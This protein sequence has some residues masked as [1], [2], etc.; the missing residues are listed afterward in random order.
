MN[1]AE[2]ATE[3]CRRLE[4]RLRVLSDA[5]R[6][7]AGATADPQ[8]LA[9]TVARRVAEAVKDCREL[10]QSLADHAALA[11]TNAHLLADAGRER[12]ERT[13]IADRLR[14]LSEAAKDFSA[15][16]G[17]LDQ[18]LE[19]IARRLGELVGDLCAIRPVSDDGEWLEAGAAYHR[20][21]ELLAATREIML[22]KPQRVGEGISGRVAAT[23]QALLTP[24]TETSAFIASSEPRYRPYLE[25]LG[26]ASSMAIPLLCRGK[27][28]GVASLLRSSPGHPYTED[29]LRFVQSVADHAALA[30]GNAQ[31]HAAERAARDAA[32]K[33]TNALRRSE[34]RFARLSEAGILG[35]LVSDLEGHVSEVNET[36]LQLVGYSR[37]EILSGRV[38]WKSLTPSE[39]RDVDARAVAQLT[40]SGVAGLREK[41]VIHKDGRRVPILAGSAMLGNESNTCISFL[42][43]LTE[44]KEAQAAI[45]HLHEER[46]V[47]ARFRGLLE[48]AP[49]AMVIV[50]SDGSIA[51]VNAQAEAL[52]GYPRA[53]MVGRPVELLIPERFR[54]AHP[55]R[56]AGYFRNAAARPMDG[57][58]ELYGRRKDGSEFPIEVSLSPLKTE[59]GNLVS[60]AIRDVTERKKAE[61]QRASLTATLARAKEGAESASRELEAFSY[62][63][64]HDLRA[65]LRGMNGFAQVLLS[66]YKEKFDAEGQD[67][68]REI[69]LNA[70]KMGDLIDGLL[71]LAHLTQSELNPAQVDLSEIVRDVAAHLAALEPQRA[72]QL[73]L[74]DHLYAQVDL[75]LARA[76]VQN[77]LANA[78]KFTSNAAEARVEFGATAKDGD[79]AFFVRDNGAGFDMAYASKLF[80]PFQRLHT[81]DEFPGT[82]I[83]LATVQRIV[84]RHGG[85]VWAEGVVDAGATFYF[86]F[87]QPALGATP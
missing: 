39:W 48:S 78:W 34:A 20:D 70:A 24:K 5:T 10:A 19:V 9:D 69:V 11:L 4:E 84:R 8:R 61:Q 50:A 60:S 56:R 46:A 29:D 71:S 66:R 31:S 3:R 26:V 83:G 58:L 74:E 81:V 52:F 79:R 42:L 73:V 13:Q 47:D 16:T 14:L 75:R 36:V 76:L 7:F 33:A 53:E 72:V 51:L 80:V 21:P 85:R 22:S 59:G 2:D 68:L 28:V 77:L 12:A 27:V 67:W 35:I 64:A 15:A 17:D 40:A 55:S 38:P 1:P 32:E 43:D 25:R 37:D 45:A 86:T 18:L 23:G 44:R 49:D 30:V 57:G 82:G 54:H 62:S 63:V 65:P 41:E 6:A 87:S